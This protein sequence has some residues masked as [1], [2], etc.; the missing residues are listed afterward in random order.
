MEGLKWFI[1]G[2]S[3]ASSNTFRFIPYLGPQEYLAKNRID[4]KV[5]IVTGANAGIGKET[6]KELALR[7]AKVS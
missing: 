4:N 2:L 7:G 3:D 6:A 1:Q 5:A